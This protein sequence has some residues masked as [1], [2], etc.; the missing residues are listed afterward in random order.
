M[1]DEI[2]KDET[3]V[4]GRRKLLQRAAVTLPAIVTVPSVASAAARSSNLIGYS[5]TS[6]GDKVLC[7][8]TRGLS[9]NDGIVDLGFSPDP[10]GKIIPTDYTYKNLS[11][12]KNYSAAGACKKG[13]D[14]K[15]TYSGKTKQFYTPPNG[16]MVSAT[17]M[18]SFGGYQAK[19]DKIV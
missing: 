14:Y 1:T 9:V 18:A 13:G 4:V 3:P 6:N 2:K 19:F 17:A 15:F 8:D 11:D 12:N 10:G 16:V 7:L 5:T